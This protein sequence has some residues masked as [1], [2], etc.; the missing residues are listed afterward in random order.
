MR[1]KDFN[2]MQR[3]IS[4]LNMEFN[5][6]PENLFLECPELIDDLK[7]E[8]GI[9]EPTILDNLRVYSLNVGRSITIIETE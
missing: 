9:K 8:Y 5:C 1:I 7:E 6:I 2:E 3:L 4:V